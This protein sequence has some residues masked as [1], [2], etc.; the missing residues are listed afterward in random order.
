LV[1]SVAG[2]SLGLLV[3][4]WSNSYVAA[5]FN[6][7]MP[8]DVRVVGFTFA[9]SLLTGALFG[10]VPALIA[11]SA[12]VNSSLKSGGR[13]ATSDRSRH[14]LRKGLVVVELGLALTLLAGAG[15]FVSGIY[16]VT[17]RDLG[18]NAKNVI[19]GY[20]ALDHDH[21]GEQKD[22]RSLVFGD[23]LRE[24]LQ[25]LPGVTAATIS[26]STPTRG[27]YYE[28]FRVEGRQA[29]EGG[30]A[31][32]AQTDTS[33]PG[34]FQVYGVELVKGRDFNDTDRPGSPSVIIVNEAMA[35]KLWPGQDPIGKR[36]GD[37]DPANPNWSE[38]V[39]VMKGFRSA[40]DFFPIEDGFQY[41]RPWAQNTHRFMTF[42]LRTSVPAG[43]MKDEVR[44]A[45]ANLS[46]DVAPVSLG[47]ATELLEGQMGVFKFVGNLLL[48]ISVLGLLLASVGI[49]GVVANLA[50]ERTKEIGI[51]MALGAE[52][53]RLLWLFLKGGMQL[54][55]IGTAA[56]LGA[57]FALLHILTKMLPIV[58]GN[59][60][61]VVACVALI[62]I[63]IS[64]VACWLPAWRASKVSPTVAL[65]A[66]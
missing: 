14:L 35:K 58:P 20:I 17:H 51:R 40:S 18:W 24:E 12:D 41:L 16:K 47:T 63:A 33:S 53:R 46:P 23:R 26:Q 31:P 3:A 62:L 37:L 65:R 36:I 66:E 42:N 55:L 50:A 1:I 9:I 21:Y 5:Y 34:F 54:A 38:V 59:D 22:A 64:V 29:P 44:K 45:L 60:P 8:L 25:A 32:F 19:V 2:G 30:K 6:F 57:S 61:R 13:G 39:G 48:E 4:K 10:T 11:S 15:F 43:P 7:D 28:A 27:M 49:Y 56:G 52:P